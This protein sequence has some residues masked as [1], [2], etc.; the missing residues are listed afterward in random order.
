[1][2]PD[3]VS[4]AIAP[5]SRPPHVIRAPDVIAGA[6]GIIRTIA[7]F[8]RDITGRTINYAA[9]AIGIRFSAASEPH[10]N[11]RQNQR[12]KNTLRPFARYHIAQT[13]PLF[14]SFTFM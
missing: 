10:S 6:P 12:A 14:R 8:D 7:H 3:P 5:V 1:V 9:G 13:N 2:D 11:S 4:V